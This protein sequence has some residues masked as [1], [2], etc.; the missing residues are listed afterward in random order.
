LILKL[1]ER[2]RNGLPNRGRRL[3]KKNKKFQGDGDYIE[4]AKELVPSF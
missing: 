1:A 4:R 2:E 3:G